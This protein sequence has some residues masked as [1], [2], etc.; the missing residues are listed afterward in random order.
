MKRRFQNRYMRFFISSLLVSFLATGCST[1]NTAMNYFKYWNS[2]PT[3]TDLTE[4]DVNQFVAK[5]RLHRGNPDSHYLLAC[6][7]QQRGRHQDAIRE[8]EKVVF[9]DPE[10]A[11]AYNGM[12]VSYDWLKD[13][14]KAIQAYQE[15]LQI[16]PGLDYVH[17]N[18]GYSYLLREDYDA[19]IKAFQKAIKLNDENTKFHNN[20]GL[21]YAMKG[22]FELALTEFER[23]GDKSK[24][25]Y[26]LASVYY[27]KGMF[28]QAKENYMKALD[29]KPTFTGAREG[30]E[31]SEALAAIARAAHRQEEEALAEETLSDVAG[32]RNVA[33]LNNAGIEVS[34]GNGVGHMAKRVASYLEDHGFN[35]VRLTNADHF[36]H[37]EGII[38][39]LRGYC[40]AARQIAEY[41]PEMALIR[42]VSGFDREYVKVR[43]LIGK[44]QV[45]YREI[46]RKKVVRS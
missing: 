10:H 43:I 32:D 20:L 7:Y 13:F 11:K 5:I 36:N 44:D 12:A 24:A 25:H 21:A 16:D 29:L 26:N 3:R 42:E 19:A 34:N 41:I 30:I 31:A 45:P 37:S 17:N 2:G 8:F 15:A 39:C 35:V 33:R 22:D 6:Y 46:Y 9:I 28:D 27:D 1:L 40:G 14:P 18:L 4:R 23:A 38:F